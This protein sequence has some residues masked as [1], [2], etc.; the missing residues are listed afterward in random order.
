MSRF[1]LCAELDC[2]CN[3][4]HEKQFCSGL[5]NTIFTRTCPFKQSPDE[6]DRKH[7]ECIWRH[8]EKHH[9]WILYEFYKLSPKTVSMMKSFDDVLDFVKKGRNKK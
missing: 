4:K 2:Q 8:I 1:P 5:D 3:A 6:W 7:A 9:N